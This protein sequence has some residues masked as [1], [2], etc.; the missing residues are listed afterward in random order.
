MIQDL[1]HCRYLK[2]QKDCDGVVEDA[3][4]NSRQSLSPVEA[5]GI[6]DSRSSNTLHVI[7]LAHQCYWAS[8]SQVCSES[9]LSFLAQDSMF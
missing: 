1:K 9:L 7:S 3:R 4:K 6:S 5:A 2:Q 8:L